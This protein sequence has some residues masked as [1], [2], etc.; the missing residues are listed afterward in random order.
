MCV[1]GV[2]ASRQSWKYIVVQKILRYNTFPK[3][4]LAHVYVMTRD[5]ISFHI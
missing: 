5:A 3:K 2:G 4:H 1:G